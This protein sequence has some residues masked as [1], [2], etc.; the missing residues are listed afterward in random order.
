VHGL[1]SAD[2]KAVLLRSIP[3]APVRKRFCIP[4]VAASEASIPVQPGADQQAGGQ[5]GQ[6]RSET[7]MDAGLGVVVK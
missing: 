2:I 7:R 3:A 6:K 4:R 5:C 1:A